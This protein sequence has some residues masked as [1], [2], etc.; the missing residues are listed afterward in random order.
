MQ[1]FGNPQHD[2]SQPKEAGKGAYAS[3]R[4]MLNAAHA[5]AN[6][7]QAALQKRTGTLMRDDVSACLASSL[8][9]RAGGDW[10]T[11]ASYCECL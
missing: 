2:Y 1:G 6:R 9:Q 4:G 5:L 10:G 7:G 8:E 3:A 11:I